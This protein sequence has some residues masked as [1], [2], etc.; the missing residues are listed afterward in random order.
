MR[1]GGGLFVRNLPDAVLF[2]VLQNDG[3]H[4]Q[5]YLVPDVSLGGNPAM[6][7]GSQVLIRDQL[8]HGIVRPSEIMGRASL[9][10]SFGKFVPGVEYTWTRDQHL[11]GSRRLPNASGWYDLLESDRGLQRRRIHAGLTYR[12]GM[13]RLFANYERIYSRDDTDGPFSFPSNQDDLRAEWARSAGVSP[14]N[15]SMG[16]NLNVR[17]A[18]YLTVIE[19][20]RD[21]ASYNVTTGLDPASNGLFTDRGGL[22]R[23]SGNGP[24]FKSM[25][26]Y[27]SRRVGVPVWPWRPH[28]KLSFSVGLQGENVLNNRNYMSTGSIEGSPTFG[29]PLGVAPGRTLRVFLGM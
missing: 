14:D 8:A 2:Q 21:S 23:N 4:F 1:A 26:L 10:R 12:L 19:S 9:E 17:K 11:L 18:F 13:Q 3:A 5:Q 6:P 15:V 20:W 24:G 25:S 28:F 27:A 29:Q 16:A 22:P 7:S